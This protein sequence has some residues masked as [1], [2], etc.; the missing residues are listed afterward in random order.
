MYAFL[1]FILCG[2]VGVLV[3]IDHPISERLGL[4]PRFLHILILI[5]SVVAI[6]VIGARA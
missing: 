3:D 4:D 2:A 6:W 5:A 1:A